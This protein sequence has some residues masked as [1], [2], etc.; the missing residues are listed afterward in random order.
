MRRTRRRQRRFGHVEPL[1]T[2]RLLAVDVIQPLPNFAVDAGAAS[3][4]IDLDAAFDLAGVTGTVVRFA[5][6]VGADVYAELFDAEGDGRTRTTPLTAANFLAYLDAGRYT[7]TIVH[8]SVAGF[9][10]QGG[11]FAVT[12]AGGNLID[13]IPQFAQLQNEPGNTNVRGTIAMAKLG[14]DPNSATNQ[15]FFNLGNNSANLDNQNGG[16][17]AFARVLGN[18]MTVVDAIAA[19]P[20]YNYGSPFD[21]LPAIGLA[22]PD[23][24]ARENLV[25]ITSVSRVG[26]LV[27]TATSSDVGVATATVGAD[28]TLDTVVVVP[29]DIP[30]G[31]HRVVITT[32]SADDGDPVTFTLGIVVREFTKESNLATW[33]IVTPILLA[34]AAALFLPPAMRRRRRS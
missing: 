23:A 14:G 3:A 10:V 28:G 19:L 29:A 21:E 15:W 31:A 24:I 18:G 9:V 25:T 34:V 22:N 6:N 20:R 16:F 32:R 4:V 13:S 1:E 26:E 11:G 5:N 7:N 33:L 2:R 27:Y 17:T 30:N 12:E 8:R